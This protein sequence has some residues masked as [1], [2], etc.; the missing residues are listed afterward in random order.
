LYSMDSYK[1]NEALLRI[2]GIVDV[3]WIPVRICKL[4]I[5]RALESS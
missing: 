4:K 2:S 1:K 5:Y 3:R